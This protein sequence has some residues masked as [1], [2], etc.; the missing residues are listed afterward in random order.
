MNILDCRLERIAENAFASLINLKSLDIRNST[1][2]F[3]INSFKNCNL[4]AIHLAD[5]Q[6]KL[7][8]LLNLKYVEQIT[9]ENCHDI[10]IPTAAFK[11]FSSLNTLTFDSCRITK[12]DLDAFDDM[13][14]L[15]ELRFM[16]CEIGYLDC[17][18]FLKL[19]SLKFVSFHSNVVN[20]D[21]DYEI[22]KNL[23]QL[24][25][26]FFDINVYK[27]MDFSG[28]PKLKTVTLGY[29]D[30]NDVAEQE[31]QKSIILKLEKHNLQYECVLT[32]KVEVNMDEVQICG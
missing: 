7:E 31:L 29:K 8:N 20:G 26:I 4:T 11:N 19:S 28:Y 25:N 27:D 17:K 10:A 5:M 18:S 14:S 30:D 3:E 15:S 32:G 2:P 9:F 1:F 16:D 13:K 21:I 12:I 23:P 22:F 24:E 6:I